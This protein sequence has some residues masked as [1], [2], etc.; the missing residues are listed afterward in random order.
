MP[1]RVSCPKVLEILPEV[2]GLSMPHFRSS[3]QVFRLS[4]I[5]VPLTHVADLPHLSG[6][7]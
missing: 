4:A 1:R 3:L 5:V 6:L 7:G 2:V